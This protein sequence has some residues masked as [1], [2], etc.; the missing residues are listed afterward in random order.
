MKGYI[1]ANSLGILGDFYT[2]IQAVG[3]DR[4]SNSTKMKQVNT[5]TAI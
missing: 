5:D 2:V 1:K 3:K 4:N